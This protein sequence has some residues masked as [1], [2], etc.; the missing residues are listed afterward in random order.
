MVP[1]RVEVSVSEQVAVRVGVGVLP[2]GCHG[3]GPARAVG[4]GRMGGRI[5]LPPTSL[6]LRTNNT[7]LEPTFGGGVSTGDAT[8]KSSFLVNDNFLFVGNMFNA[9]FVFQ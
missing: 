2:T 5:S 3:V 1:L 8:R 9:N 6:P 7:S 4:E